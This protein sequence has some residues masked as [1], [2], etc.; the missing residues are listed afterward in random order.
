MLSPPSANYSNII[1]QTSS[2]TESVLT[3]GPWAKFETSNE[4]ITLT[5]HRRW[6]E[7][8]SP[9]KGHLARNFNTNQMVECKMSENSKKDGFCLEWKDGFR[10]EVFRHFNKRHK[11]FGTKLDFECS[12]I[13]W[14]PPAN[15]SVKESPEDCFDLSQ[16]SWFGGFEESCQSWP[17]NGYNINSSAFITADTY[18]GRTFGSVIEGIFLSSSGFGIIVDETTPLYVSINQYKMPLLCLKGR[19]GDDTPFFN[20]TQPF[21]KYDMCLSKNLLSLWKGISASHLPKPTL[22]PSIDVI[23]YPIWCTWAVYKDRI[24]QS[25][26]VNYAKSIRA[27]NFSVSQ[28]EIDDSWT[29]HYGDFNFTADR[30]PNAVEMIQNLTDLGIPATVWIHPFFNKD[31]DAFKELAGKGFLVKDFDSDDPHMVSWWRSSHNAGILDMTNPDAVKWYLDRLD[32]LKK[33][34]NVTSFKFD[35]GEAIWYPGKYKLKNKVTNPNYLSRK[36]IELALQSDLDQRRQEMRV[37]FRSQNSTLMLR[38]IDRQSD[39]SH[40]LGIKTLI[41]AALAFGMMG[42]PYILPDMIGGDDYLTGSPDPELFIR[43]L[44]ASIFLPV[45]QMSI[46]PWWFNDSVVQLTRRY[47][48]LH[49][50]YAD[51]IIELALNA[52]KTGEPIIRPLWWIAPDDHAAIAIDSEFLLGDILLVAPVLEKGA[53]SRDIYLPNGVWR[54]EQTGSLIRG[55]I[56]L[57]GYHAPLDVLPYFTRTA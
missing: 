24:N 28:L 46:P 47:L 51:V 19:V 42:Y 36:Y 52:V 29:L 16:F 53:V 26:V 43:W 20:V 45:I 6:T 41:P 15:S 40:T 38:L 1:D 37:G 5:A 23:R 25:I 14:K 35:A 11:H 55:A 32:Y 2:V 9:V 56:W 17:M 31:S 21:L 18:M 39:W 22:V 13:Y 10:L 30:F 3:A 48:H 54:D 12:T 27:H 4:G 50:E 34:F 8:I 44:Q 7:L 33:T 49:E 57:Y